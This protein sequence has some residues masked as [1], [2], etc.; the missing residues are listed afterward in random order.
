MDAEAQR[1]VG[2]DL[3]G[4]VS[5][6]VLVHINIAALLEAL[7]GEG[8]P[9]VAG[10]GHARPLGRADHGV[11]QNADLGAAIAALRLAGFGRN[12]LFGAAIA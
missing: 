1:G 4:A 6:L 5:D 8:N 10:I 2:V 7:G 3:A 11:P 9:G 12:V